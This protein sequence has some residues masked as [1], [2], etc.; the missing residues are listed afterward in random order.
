MDSDLAPSPLLS[1][2][3]PG[4][5]RLVLGDFKLGTICVIDTKPHEA[6]SEE[7]AHM[8][9]LL[10]KQ[11]ADGLESRLAARRIEKA[12]EEL[13]RNAMELHATNNEL[14]ALIDTANAPIF[15]IDEHYQAQRA[16]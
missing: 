6:F 9:N 2:G 11:V 15:A 1:F 12:N 16:A 10:A 7:E 3:A 14:S 5:C 13:R 4:R 8:L